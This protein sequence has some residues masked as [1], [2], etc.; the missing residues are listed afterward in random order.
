MEFNSTL[1]CG[2]NILPN[3]ILVNSHNIT[4]VPAIILSWVS[5]VLLFLFIGLLTIDSS[6]GRHPY[7][8]F[9][10]IWV[11]SVIVTGLVSTYLIMS[12]NTINSLYNWFS[13]IW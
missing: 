6:G 1:I 5:F 12:P 13:G 10:I 7:K 11:I 9:M 4:A 8:K 2:N 3:D